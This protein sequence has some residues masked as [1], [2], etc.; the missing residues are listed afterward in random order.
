LHLHKRVRSG[1]DLLQDISLRIRPRELV[2]V[3]GLSGAGKTSLLNALAGYHPATD[4]QVLVDGADLYEHFDRFRPTI[5]FV[6]QR[7]IIHRDLTVYEALDYAARLRMPPETTPEGRR[8]RIEEVMADM[9]LTE[10]RDVRVRSLSGGQQKRVSIGVELITS[11]QLFFLDEPT[12]G[13]DPGTETG[14]MQ[15]LR[16][17][18]DQGRTVILITHATKNVMLADKVLFM[19]RGGYIAW[20]GPPTEALTYFN[21]QRPELERDNGEL[22]FDA[23]YSLLEDA[24]RG[25]PQDWAERYQNDPAYQKY[26]AAPLHLT[27]SLGAEQRREPGKQPPEPV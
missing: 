8:Q 25:T 4:G 26:I 5:G 27:P 18:A 22:E 21:R 17:L 14:V 2:I 1:I 10:R 7:D 3:V 13:L 12:S 15:L 20:Y 9:D 11:P 16:R 19:V 24:S 23:I 6:P